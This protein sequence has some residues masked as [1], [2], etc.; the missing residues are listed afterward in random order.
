MIRSISKANEIVL[1]GVALVQGLKGEVGCFLVG[2]FQNRAYSWR[3]L[4]ITN[5]CF[6]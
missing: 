3:F 5:P 6:K 1:R 4:Q 2:Y